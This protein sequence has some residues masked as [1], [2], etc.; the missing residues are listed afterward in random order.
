MM[1]FSLPVKSSVVKGKTW[2]LVGSSHNVRKFK[3]YRWDPA[4]ENPSRVDTYEV[5]MDNCGP[6]CC[7]RHTVGWRTVVTKLP[8]S[9]STTWMTPIACFV[10]TQY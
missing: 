7:C 3:I 1:K 8:A 2:A 10:V 6:L 5:D 4:T 9:A